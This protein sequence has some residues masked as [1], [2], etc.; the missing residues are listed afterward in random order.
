MGLKPGSI[1][2]EA[3]EIDSIIASLSQVLKTD[4]FDPG[5]YFNRAIA[6]YYQKNYNA[7]W[8]DLHKAEAL[9][10]KTDQ[11]YLKFLERLCSASGRRE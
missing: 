3:K 8:S 5:I 1:T 6:Y 2:V 11:K 10:I 7:S 4:P 9:G